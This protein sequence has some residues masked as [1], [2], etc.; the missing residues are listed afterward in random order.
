V[1]RQVLTYTHPYPCE[2]ATLHWVAPLCIGLHKQGLSGS[3]RKIPDHANGQRE[4]TWLQSCACAKE[5][6]S[7]KEFVAG[8]RFT[9]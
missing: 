4:I 1:L 5:R 3:P 9:R 7:R 6:G 8:A 2:I